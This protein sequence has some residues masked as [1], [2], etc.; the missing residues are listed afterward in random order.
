[1][2]TSTKSF[3]LYGT[4]AVLLVLRLTVAKTGVC[5][6]C[7][8]C[9]E[10]KVKF[11]GIG[12]VKVLTLVTLLLAFIFAGTWVAHQNSP[13]GWVGQNIMVRYA[14]APSPVCFVV[15]EYLLDHQ[16]LCSLTRFFFTQGICMMILVLQVVHMPNIKV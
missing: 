12:N 11:P 3:A 7:S 13:S 1:M 2:I 14:C 8:R 5:R 16:C 9:G 4:S 15:Q 10:P 6:A